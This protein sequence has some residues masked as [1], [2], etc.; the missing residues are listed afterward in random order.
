MTWTRCLLAL[1][2]R[3]ES[4]CASNRALVLNSVVEEPFQILKSLLLGIVCCDLE[5]A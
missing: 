3:L 4:F 1:G 2:V 5:L